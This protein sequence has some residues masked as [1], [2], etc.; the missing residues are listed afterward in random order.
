MRSKAV[1]I[2]ISVFALSG[3]LTV[4]FNKG[5]HP[6]GSLKFKKRINNQNIVLEVNDSLDI[7]FSSHQCG[8]YGLAGVIIP[9]IPHWQNHDCSDFDI[10]VRKSSNVYL[11]HGDKIY[12]YSRFDP[13]S[14]YTYT[15]PVPVK[16]L[17][18]GAILVIEKD[19]ER[20]EIPFRYQH[21]FSFQLWGT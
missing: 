8:Y 20:F 21:S 9:V 3:C 6:D 11:K 1:S 12:T 17:S 2:L 18:D 7:E 5:A 14:Y 16:S 10:G 4:G 13:R 15:F 19:G